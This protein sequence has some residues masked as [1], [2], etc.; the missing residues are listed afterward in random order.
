MLNHVSTVAIDGPAGSGKSTVGAALAARLGFLYFDTGVMY[1]AVALAAVRRGINPAD[2]MAISRMAE[3]LHIEVFPATRDDGRQY[4]V[5]LDGDDVTWALR[6][7]EVEAHVSTVASFPAVREAMVRQQRAVAR[8]GN[9][10]MVGRD[11]GTVVLPNADVKVFLTASAEERALRR[12]QELQA[13]GIT[14]SYADVLAGVRQRDDIDSNRATSPLRPAEDAVIF[15]ST[16]LSVDEA[17][18]GVFRLVASVT[19]A[20]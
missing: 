8:Q 1:R 11:I 13:R 20:H 7:K 17:V 2:E 9:I 19:D 16:G 15:D 3:A 5:R 18:E 4:T 10:V 12:H 6:D 14:A